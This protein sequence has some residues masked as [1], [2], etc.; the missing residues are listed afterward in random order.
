MID[1][2]IN[3]IPYGIKIAEHEICSIKIVND[4]TG[5]KEI[6]N[7]IVNIK[8]SGGFSNRNYN[9]YIEDHYRADGIM[10]LLRKIIET[11]KFVKNGG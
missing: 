5:N 7:Y 11:F 9:L 8:E 1:V 10:E 2:K 6:G 4:G 3:M